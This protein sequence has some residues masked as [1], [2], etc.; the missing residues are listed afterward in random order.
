M[1]STGHSSMPDLSSRSTQGCAM[2]YV[3]SE[4]LFRLCPQGVRSKYYGSRK[5]G[6]SACLHSTR[7][8]G[9]CVFHPAGMARWRRPKEPGIPHLVQPELA[10]VG[11]Q[12]GG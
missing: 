8:R 10:G 9:T 3:T 6:G 4:R 1:Q 12:P 7:S 5:P 2:M 11:D